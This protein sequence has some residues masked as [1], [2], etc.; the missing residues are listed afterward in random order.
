KYC[1]KYS[2]GCHLASLDLQEESEDMAVHIS[3]KFKVN[4]W[5]GL[6]RPSHVGYNKWNN[7]NCRPS[8]ILLPVHSLVPLSPAPEGVKLLVKSGEVTQLS[9]RPKSLLCTPS[10]HG[11]FPSLGSDFA[12]PDMARRVQVEK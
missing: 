8:S 6:S 2:H 7:E 1:K 9:C 12:P 10:L 4:I 5:I 11:C 3:Q